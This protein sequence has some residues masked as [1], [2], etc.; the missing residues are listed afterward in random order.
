[1]KRNK[2][3]VYI[4]GRG[5]LDIAKNIFDKITSNSAAQNFVTSAVKKAA[6]T[7]GS[8]L[9][10]FAANKI[11]EKVLPQSKT[12]EANKIALKVLPESKTF[13]ANKIAEKLLPQSKTL[14]ALEELENKVRQDI[15]NYQMG[16]GFKIIR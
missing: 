10:E 1:M 16:S 7:G 13:E 11:A 12:F 4:Q 8:K 2:V 6:E 15:Q 3:R 14:S 5:F 9:G